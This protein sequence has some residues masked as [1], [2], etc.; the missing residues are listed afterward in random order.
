MALKTVQLQIYIYQGTSGSY[1]STD[2]KY[3]LQNSLI[4]DDTN[5]IFEISELVR[6][7]LNISFNDDYNSTT[8][9]VTTVATLLDE[10]NNVFTY[11]SPITNHYLAVEGYGFFEDGTS[12][13]LSRNAL[14]TS[15][16]IYLPENTAGKLPIFAEGVGKYI[17]DSTTT[18]VTDNG[19]SNQKIQYINIPANSST[20]QI[21]DT[22][23]ATLVKTINVINICE[24][25]FTPYKVTFV[26]KYG[27]YQDL[28]F[29]KKSVESFDVTDEMYKM[30]T[31][32]NA[33]AT[34]NKY[35]G[36]KQRYN[37][38]ASKSITLNTGF[39][40]EDS[41][42]TIEELFLSEN[43][44][45]R[46]GSDTLPIIPKSKSL[47]FKTQLNDNLANYTIRFEFAF[48]KINNVR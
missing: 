5:V 35:E 36:Q 1:A 16:T 24:P 13:E 18:Q 44:W 38:N 43:V 21:Y 32:S 28:Y 2:L 26:N 40:N 11:G 39:I 37:S 29:F 47:T 10:N 27:A 8:V 31:I 20:I 15:N 23:D 19:N 25:K 33:T 41:N 6:D 3:T 45:I 12:P 14:I 7:Y 22:D 48:N 46:Q 30:N 34:Y 4:G 42:S 9:W 17:I